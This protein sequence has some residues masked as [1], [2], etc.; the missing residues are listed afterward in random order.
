MWAKGA[1]PAWPTQAPAALLPAPRHRSLLTTASPYLR[2]LGSAMPPAQTFLRTLPGHRSAADPAGARA[3]QAASAGPGPAGDAP[4]RANPH[5]RGLHPAQNSTQNLA[6]GGER[7]LLME[8]TRER[9]NLAPQQA[10]RPLGR[11]R[12]AAT[13]ERFQI[14]ARRPASRG[15]GTIKLACPAPSSCGWHSTLLPWRRPGVRLSLPLKSEGAGIS[16]LPAVSMPGAETSP[17]AIPHPP[18]NG[19][20]KQLRCYGNCLGQCAGAQRVI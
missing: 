18:G 14:L 12:P 7:E 9:E 17:L 6:V 2:A 13:A 19:P 4:P 20:S 10:S 15:G 16:A 3:T 11:R 5:A 1:A 8:E